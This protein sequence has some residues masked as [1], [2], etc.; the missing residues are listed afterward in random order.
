MVMPTAAASPQASNVPAARGIKLRLRFDA[1]STAGA[2]AATR[3]PDSP[4]T[5]LSVLTEPQVRA[6]VTAASARLEQEVVGESTEKTTDLGLLASAT[7]GVALTALAARDATAE[8]EGSAEAPPTSI[9][10]AAKEPFSEPVAIACLASRSLPSLPVVTSQVGEE[11][12]GGAPARPAVRQPSTGAT[13]ASP[14]STPPSGV[15][16]GV[17]TT[18]ASA[19]WPDAGWSG[20]QGSL[21]ATRASSDAASIASDNSEDASSR[22][23]GVGESEPPSFGWTTPVVVLV[24]C[25]TFTA[26]CR[27]KV[28]LVKYGCRQLRSTA[29]QRKTAPDRCREPGDCGTLLQTLSDLSNM[30]PTR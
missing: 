2:G 3:M 8:L 10:V 13:A 25:L 22:D 24:A 21:A 7:T 23:Q 11:Q 19:G 28:L 29:P 4:S 9:L 15:T 12:H 5:W 17:A 6:V 27:A 16:D 1:A 18:D 30:H 20:A 26:A 14:T